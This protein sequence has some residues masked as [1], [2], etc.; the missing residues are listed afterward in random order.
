MSGIPD[1]ICVRAR[2]RMASFVFLKEKILVLH[3]FSWK[4]SLPH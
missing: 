3:D 2:L 4:E 1:K